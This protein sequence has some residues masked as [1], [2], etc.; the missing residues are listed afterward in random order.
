[1]AVRKIV[2]GN[3][4]KNV[5]APVQEVE[6]KVEDQIVDT[7]T[8]K[9]NESIEEEI[10]NEVADESIEETIVEEE[11][12]EELE[13]VTPVKPTVV[14]TTKTTKTAV[15]KNPVATKSVATATPKATTKKR[16][17]SAKT[18]SSKTKV[19]ET[20]YTRDRFIRDVRDQLAEIYDNPTLVESEALINIVESVLKEATDKF[21]V[22]FLGGTIKKA[23]R[24]ALV[25]KAPKVDYHTY[26]EAREVKTL[27]LDIGQPAKY[28]GTVSEDGKTF[29]YDGVYNN[30]T[31]VYDAEEG[32]IEL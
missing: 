28:K 16:F 22:R 21:S 7:D 26:K 27:T 13:E 5:V 30:E 10:V 4:K 19:E 14:K 31:K 8:Q 9:L 2:K 12:V 29:L 1:M 23:S 15:T 20:S 18:P 3:V 6:T 11:I 17:G 24:N 32:T 25:S